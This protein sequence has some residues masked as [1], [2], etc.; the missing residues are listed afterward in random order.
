MDP[1]GLLN[2]KPNSGIYEIVFYYLELNQTW[3]C[4]IVGKEKEGVTFFVTP[5]TIFGLISG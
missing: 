4:R 3:L 1:K 5:L 2:R